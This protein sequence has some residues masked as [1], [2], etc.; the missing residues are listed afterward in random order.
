MT[1]QEAA[2]ID[3]RNKSNCEREIHRFVEAD[4]WER[5]CIFCGK[6]ETTKPE[7]DDQ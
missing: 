6:F 7:G 5:T 3:L 4:E 1:S 2:A